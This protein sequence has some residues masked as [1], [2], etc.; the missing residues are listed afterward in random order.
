MA[1]Y[2]ASWNRHCLVVR[3]GMLLVVIDRRVRSTV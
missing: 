2:G 3:N 1:G